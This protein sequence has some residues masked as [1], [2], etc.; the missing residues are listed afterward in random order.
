MM[1]PLPNIKKQKGFTLTE[2]IIVVI[3]LGILAYLGVRAIA[4]SSDPANAAAIRASSKEIAKGVG[5]LHTNLGTGLSAT[6]NALPKSGL[7]M[8]DVLMVGEEAV[9][10][11]YTTQYRQAKMRP[12]EGEFKVVARPSG[13]TPGTY[14]LLTYPV[15]VVACATGKVCVRLA[16]VPSDTVADLAGKYGL[17]FVAATAQTTGPLRYTAVDSEGFH[18]VTLEQ[19]P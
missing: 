15:T 3:I 13:S 1:K 5:Y 18:T 7:N 16:N 17:T 8:L 2:L 4:G 6:A 19:V 9:A 11:T 10:T 12:L 14:E